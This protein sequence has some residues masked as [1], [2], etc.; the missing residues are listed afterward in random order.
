MD[1]GDGGAVNGGSEGERRPRVVVVGAGFAGLWAVQR[2]RREPVDVLLL[3]RQNYHTFLPLLYQVAAAE[4]GPTDIAYPVRSIL[5]DQKNATFR[6]AEVVEVDL[7]HSEVVT[8]VERI[9]YD[10]LILGMGATTHY[11]GVEGAEEYAFPLRT[12]DEAIPLRHH[13]LSRFEEAAYEADAEH[14]QRLLTFAIVGAGPTGVEFSGALSE[15]IYG[16]LQKDFPMIDMATVR[17]LLIEAM[18]GVLQ[19]MPAELS[20]Y[21]RDRLERRKVELKMGSAVARV[22]PDWVE[23]EGGERIGTETIVWTGG[24]RGAQGP[25]DWGL[26]VTR[27]G[28]IEVE[29]TLAVP[30]RPGVWAAG[31]LAYL[32][33]DGEPLPGVA[34]VALQQGTLAADNIMR[35]IR[36]EE[37]KAFHYR[38]PGMLAVIG[39]NAAVARLGGRNFKGFPA[40]VVWLVV[41]VAKLIGFRNRV[42]VLVN[43][44]WNYLF[45]ER[46]VR[47]ILPFARRSAGDRPRPERPRPLPRGGGSGEPVGEE[48]V[49]ADEPRG[50]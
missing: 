29:R 26:P 24:V 44:A 13:V 49:A 37:P 30:G 3:D 28:Q 18:D 46:A 20:D 45:F 36:G 6:M 41:H 2:L 31:D 33:E 47:L 4:L 42:L 48:G 11:F 43:W 12:M 14:R 34:P 39:R 21:A 32:E 1:A 19:G 38:D 35:Q 10:H 50:G 16:P 22:G 15:L 23:I 9:P 5:R 40:W 27:S 7:E 25:R 17:I 8:P